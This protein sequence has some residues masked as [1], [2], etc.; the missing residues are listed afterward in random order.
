M[1]RGPAGA[2]WRGGRGGQVLQPCPTRGGGQ[3]GSS[4]PQTKVEESRAHL[5]CRGP[6]RPPPLQ[7]HIAKIRGSTETGGRAGGYARTNRTKGEPR[8]R[9]GL[10]AEN[11]LGVHLAQLQRSEQMKGKGREGVRVGPERTRGKGPKGEGLKRQ[12]AQGGRKIVFL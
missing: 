7:S 9:R 2:G 1:G 3:H 11:P 8:R 5:Q 12:R 6:E 4:R 10:A